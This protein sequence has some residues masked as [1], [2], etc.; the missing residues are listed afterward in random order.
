[1]ND[2]LYRYNPW[3]EEIPNAS[4][5]FERP[6]ILDR[7]R[8]NL[9]SRDILMLT[10]LRRVGKT[11]IMKMLIHHLLISA[12]VRP[13]QILYLSLD[14][15]RLFSVTLADII[16][17]VRK[18]HRLRFDEKLYIFFDEVTHHPDYEIQLKNLYDSEN[19][20]LIVSS[21][22]ATMMKS[23]KGFLTGRNRLYEILPLDFSEYL[24]FKSLTPKKRDAHL[25]ESYFEDF[26]RT[27][28]IPEYVLR[29]EIEYLKELVDDIIL[30]DIAAV[31]GIKQP[32]VLK[33]FF[34]LLLERAGKQVSLNKLAHILGIAPDSAKRYLEM[35]NDSYLIHL[36]SRQG[37][38]NERL[39]SPKKLY[40]ADLGIRTFYTGF[41]DIGS[42]FEN[43]IY[44]KLR[45]Y[46]P[47]YIVKDGIEIDFMTEKGILIEAKYNS[48]MT[49]KQAA[50]FDAVR[51]KK[52]IIIDTV[53]SLV[54]L[55]TLLGAN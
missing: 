31:Y 34:L 25:M 13:Q 47:S 11:T 29:G 3:W 46:N 52:K 32:Q 51:A 54:K 44:L 37:K 48:R 49:D 41:R 18:L 24:T 53:S 55:E 27:G 28:G 10:G 4:Q 15:Y 6:G 45:S 36:V 2:L 30:K 7:I 1:M 40:A 12:Q 35:F 20:K 22:S 5:Y 23:K 26:L 21:S 42:L 43:Y 14:D 17:A 9:H 33:D 39:L 16:D 8:G 50:L 19:V 38:T